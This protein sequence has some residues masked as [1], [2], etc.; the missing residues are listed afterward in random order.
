MYVIYPYTALSFSITKVTLVPGDNTEVYK[1]YNEISHPSFPDLSRSPEVITT[2]DVLGVSAG[3]FPY[4]QVCIHVH[5]HI[6][7]DLDFFLDFVL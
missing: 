6:Q 2:N 5:T 4:T 1:V 3:I 7:I